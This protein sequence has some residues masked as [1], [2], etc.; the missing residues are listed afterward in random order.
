[1]R[2]AV[3]FD[4]DGTL[5]DVSAILHFVKGEDRDYDA[6]HGAAIDCP[7]HMYVVEAVARAREGGNAIVIVTARSSKW[8]DYTI[9]WLDKYDVAFDRLYMRIEA[10]FRHDYLVKADILK[11]IRKDGFAPIHAWD[12]SPKVI[13]LWREN[14]IDVTEVDGQ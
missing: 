4:M 1:M 6:F 8:R 10:D 12:D 9:M 14:G 13:A 5:C 2:D 3:I 11:A 7:P